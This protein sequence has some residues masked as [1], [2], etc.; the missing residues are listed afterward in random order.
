LGKLSLDRKS[1]GHAFGP[2]RKQ[3]VVTAVAVGFFGFQSSFLLADENHQGGYQLEGTCADRGSDTAKTDPDSGT[4]AYHSFEV[5]NP[6]SK[7]SASIRACS[8]KEKTAVAND[9]E[10][11]ANQRTPLD[12][13]EK[14]SWDGSIDGTVRLSPTDCSVLDVPPASLAILDSKLAARRKKEVTGNTLLSFVRLTQ[15]QAPRVIAQFLSSDSIYDVT[16]HVSVEHLCDL[17]GDAIPE[18]IL[19]DERYAGYNFWVLK[20][21]PSHSSL[22]KKFADGMRGD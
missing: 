22:E 11:A 15:D 3:A 16:R 12:Q 9:S 19:K 5:T 17:D 20:I 8:A 7:L 10:A 14:E 6:H 13:D 1:D 2:I 18:I 21:D 4:E